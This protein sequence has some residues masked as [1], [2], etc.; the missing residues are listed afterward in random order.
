MP[1]IRVARDFLAGFLLLFRGGSLVIRHPQLR[2]RAVKPFLLTVVLY[3]IG[4]GVLVHTAREQLALMLNQPDPWYLV[5]GQVALALVTVAGILVVALFAFILVARVIASPFLAQLSEDTERQVRGHLPEESFAIG[6]FVGDFG[7]AI[8]HSLALVCLL[9]M[10]FP[11]SFIP[12]IGPIVWI[13]SGWILLAY[14]FASFTL[15]R[16]HWS[17]K[18]KYALLRSVWPR[19]LGF[20]AATFALM[21]VPLGGLLVLPAATVAGTLLV[22]ELEVRYCDKNRSRAVR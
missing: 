15:D 21:A 5:L 10:T 3:G 16:R 2:Q 8:G 19:V 14:D 4:G 13:G 7:R 12:V 17:L 18:K 11:L 9:G 20:G 6:T 1:L 22:L